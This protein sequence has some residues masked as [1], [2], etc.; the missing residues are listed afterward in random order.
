[1]QP[2]L[3]S[4]RDLR[5]ADLCVI[6]RPVLDC[7]AM[8]GSMIANNKERKHQRP[9][10]SVVRIVVEIS[11]AL[12][13]ELVVLYV[14]DVVILSSIIP[15]SKPCP[16]GGFG[17]LAAFLYIIPLLYVIVSA[18]SAVAIYFV[19]STDKQTGSFLATLVCSFMGGIFWVA[20]VF[21][22]TEVPATPIYALIT[23]IMATFG[24]NMTRRYK[25]Q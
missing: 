17:I 1:M 6:M 22:F 11:A 10:L 2:T 3:K 12:A 24:F 20:F 5:A 25:L 16:S 7:K 18:V 23:A 13:L 14:F 19:G 9:P 21:L 15:E 8:D 4:L